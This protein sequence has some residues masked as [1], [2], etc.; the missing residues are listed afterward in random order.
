MIGPFSSWDSTCLKVC[1][2]PSKQDKNT[3]KNI[4]V[5]LYTHFYNISLNV[6]KPAFFNIRN[7]L[8]SH[9]LNIRKIR[10]KVG[11]RLTTIP[12]L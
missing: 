5:L 6:L 11:Q 10:V 3:L 1:E 12:T 8:F 4:K 9:F 2:Y 7:L